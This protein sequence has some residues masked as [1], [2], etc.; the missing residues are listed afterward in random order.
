MSTA[1]ED[2]VKFL[3]GLR[4]VREYTSEPVDQAIVDDI[5][6]VGR[7]SG[8]SANTQPTELV[9]IRDPE[10]KQKIGGWGAKP[11][12][13][14]A[15]VFLILSKNNPFTVDEGRLG[16]RLMLAAAAHGL[17]ASFA[18][19]KNEGPEAVKQLLGIP[20]DL[21]AHVAISIGHIDRPR[22]SPQAPRRTP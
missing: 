13:T 6:E 16:E 17:G 9:V 2:L 14:A 5:L 15:V 20:A 3:R 10:V 8:T 1:A 21:H 4:Q 18:T 19:L 11:A 12:A 7:W 22:R